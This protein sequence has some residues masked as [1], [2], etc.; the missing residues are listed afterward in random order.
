MSNG[1]CKPNELNKNYISAGDSEDRSKEQLVFTNREISPKNTIPT[2]YHRLPKNN[3][4]LG[5]KLREEART[6]FLQKRSKELLN[7]NELK[8]LWNHLQ[9]N[10]TPPSINYEH[11]IS[12]ESYLKVAN[13]AG[14]KFK[15]VYC[16]IKYK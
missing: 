2:F 8:V 16:L 9:M 12:Y 13:L 11:Y 1:T 5:L 4:T 7:N 6:L 14:E 3:D 10:Y 15:Y